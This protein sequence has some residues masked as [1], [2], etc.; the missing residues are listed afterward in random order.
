MTTSFCSD[1]ARS[2]MDSTSSSVSGSRTCPPRVL[3]TDGKIRYTPK[4]GFGDDDDGDDDD[5]AV[6]QADAGHDDPD[7]QAEEDALAHAGEQLQAGVLTAVAISLVHSR[8][9]SGSRSDH[10]RAGPEGGG[11]AAASSVGGGITTKTD[12]QISSERR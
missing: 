10:R 4:I 6:A 5:A 11:K 12:D 7:E 9:S 3:R 2:K 8:S 1:P